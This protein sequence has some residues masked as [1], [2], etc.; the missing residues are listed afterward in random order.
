M[1]LV[2]QQEKVLP[3]LDPDLKHHNTIWAAAGTANA[4]FAL[5]PDEL[6]LLTNGTWVALALGEIHGRVGK[7]VCALLYYGHLPWL[8]E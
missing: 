3:V 2:A 1:P 5:K 4:V 6:D 8:Y 7:G